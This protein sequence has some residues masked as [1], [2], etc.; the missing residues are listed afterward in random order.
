M[1]TAFDFT[2][3]TYGG[4]SFLYDADIL[5]PV[6]AG[7]GQH[8]AL[9]AVRS[10]S[11]AERVGEHGHGYVFVRSTHIPMF[12]GEQ[13][14]IFACEHDTTKEVYRMRLKQVSYLGTRDPDGR[15]HMFSIQYEEDL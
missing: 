14:F 3:G 15:S 1:T 4:I 13:M 10:L 11:W 5:A 12:V 2:F 6:A 8:A 7:G 9:K